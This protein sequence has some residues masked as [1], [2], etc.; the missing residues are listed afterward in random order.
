MSY[1]FTVSDNR[2]FGNNEMLIGTKY[3]IYS[4][5]INNDGSVNLEDIL[6][7][8]NAA[9]NFSAGYYKEDVNG[10]SLVELNDVL[11]VYNNAGN[12]VHKITP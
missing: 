5:D 9:S 4:G 6:G 8:S 2:A 1:D 7:A 10:N 3:C 12:F 11:T